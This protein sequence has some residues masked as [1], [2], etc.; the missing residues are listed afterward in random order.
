MGCLSSALTKD[1]INAATISFTTITLLLF[2]GFLP[3][4]LNITSPAIRELFSYI[5]VIQHMQDFSKGIID[6][7]VIVW[8]GS[9]TVLMLFVTLQVFQFRKW[10][11]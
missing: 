6:S 8:Y 11:A 1:Q 5:S 3:E 10:K 7:R 4:V 9:M 2:L